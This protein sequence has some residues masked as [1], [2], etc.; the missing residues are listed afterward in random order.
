MSW[1]HL[2]V[3]PSLVRRVCVTLVGATSL[4]FCALL[5]YIYQSVLAQDSG[6]LDRAARVVVVKFAA[7]LDALQGAEQMQLVAKAVSAIQS[8]S[9]GNGPAPHWKFTAATPNGALIYNDSPLPF[10]SIAALPDGSNSLSFDGRTFRVFTHSERT[11]KLWLV[12]QIQERANFLANFVFPKLL[13]VF[14]IAVPLLVLP[15]WLAVRSG[16]APLSRLSVQMAMR[17]ESDLSPITQPTKYQELTPLV[18]ALNQL[19]SR[20]R[21]SIDREKSF[22]H[23]AALGRRSHCGAP[24]R[25]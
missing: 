17:S 6:E 20:V 25:S 3:D 23:D 19:L 9:S 4:L 5:G 18:D 15:V 21:K 22:V 1:M 7:E 10:E 13:A 8:A 11:V 24:Q 14:L 12:D 16:L 2:H